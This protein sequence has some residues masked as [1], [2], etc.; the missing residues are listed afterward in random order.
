[1]GG[2]GTECNFF[3]GILDGLTFGDWRPVSGG[4]EGFNKGGNT[5]NNKE[6]LLKAR[7]KG[8]G[9]ENHGDGRTIV[10]DDSKHKPG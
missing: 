3:I 10:R 7:K 4:E 8:K 9:I 5:W 2:K 6:K 1:M